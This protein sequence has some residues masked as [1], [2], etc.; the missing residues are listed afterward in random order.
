MNIVIILMEGVSSKVLEHTLREGNFLTPYL[1]ELI[2]KSY[3]FS[4]IYSAGIHTNNGIVATLYGYP[5]QFNKPMMPSENVYYTGLPVTLRE[6]GHQTHFFVTGNPQYDN[7]NL[8]LRNN[9]FDNIHSQYNYPSDKIVNQFGVPDRYLFEY[10]LNMLNSSKVKAPFLATFLTVSNHPPLVI[11]DEYKNKNLTDY[12]AILT[13][14]DDCI[15]YFMESASK[16]DW[17]ENTLF[18]LTGDHGNLMGEQPYAMSLSY[19]QIPLIFYS[20]QFED[21]PQTFEQPGLQ[22]DV[23]PSIMELLGY[24]YINN[25]F[26]ESLFSHTRPYAYFV[27]DTYMG[28]VN[29]E[30]F[31]MF[32]PLSREESLY[33][34]KEKSTENILPLHPEI[35]EDMKTY[36]TSMLRAADYIVKSGL[37]GPDIIK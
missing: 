12:E 29:E 36:G 27:S 17:Y 3:Y 9:G 25:T 4:N 22:I 28:C 11:P 26:G 2:N 18:V 16:E 20:P 10:G 37:S 19:N 32:N 30:L 14:T 1:H 13:Y 5:T 24:S 35:A 6:N 33:R 23:Y 31:Y 21:A 7:M 15:R 8:F 34:Y